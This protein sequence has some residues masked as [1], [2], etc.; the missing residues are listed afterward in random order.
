ML[1]AA[2]IIGTGQVCAAKISSS[3][4]FNYNLRTVLE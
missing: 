3:R 1:N 2:G 4:I